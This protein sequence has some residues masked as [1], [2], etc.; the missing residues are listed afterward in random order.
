MRN[1]D[2]RLAAVV[3]D[4]AGVVAQ[5]PAFSKV[6]PERRCIGLEIRVLVESVRDCGRAPGR[7]GGRRGR[8]GRAVPRLPQGCGLRGGA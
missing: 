1:V 5:F 2:A 7:R 8:R 6:W 3:A 4:E